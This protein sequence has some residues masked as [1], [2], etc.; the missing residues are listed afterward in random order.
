MKLFELMDE[1]I[2]GIDHKIGN[3]DEQEISSCFYYRPHKAIKYGTY[4]RDV[5]ATRCSNLERA[6]DVESF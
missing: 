2:N 6:Y 4:R 3:Q 5:L 1:E